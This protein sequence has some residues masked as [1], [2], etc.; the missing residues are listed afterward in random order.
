MVQRGVTF[1]VIEVTRP[2]CS[3]AKM[4]AKG[5]SDTWPCLGASG[6][7]ILHLEK[8]MRT[9]VRLE[10]ETGGFSAAGPRLV[11][12]ECWKLATLGEGRPR[13]EEEEE[14]DEMLSRGEQMAGVVSRR[15]PLAPSV[16]EVR[17]HRLTHTPFRSWCPV[18]IASRGRDPPHRRRSDRVLSHPQ[19]HLDYFFP[20]DGPGEDSIS[21]VVM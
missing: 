18:C 16:E 19:V 13:G 11:R 14:E 15:I 9:L 5:N 17:L 7:E 12:P 4:C 1:Q 8:G 3:V 20:R 6:G 10:D 21:A 2:L